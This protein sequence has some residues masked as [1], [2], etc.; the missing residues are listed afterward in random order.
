[1]RLAYTPPTRCRGGGV[2]FARIPFTYRDCGEPTSGLEPLSCSLRV[3]H[4]A[5]QGVAEACESRISRQ[6]S[7]LWLAACCTVLRSRWYQSGIK[8][9]QIT[10]HR[11]LTASFSDVDPHRIGHVWRTYREIDAT[12]SSFADLRAGQD[13]RNPLLE[14][15]PVGW[16]LFALGDAPSD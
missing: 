5:L 4:Q 14:L 3:I 11:H 2:S 1:M 15:P 10:P 12:G 16:Q 7:L 6:L 13:Q 9:T 8:T